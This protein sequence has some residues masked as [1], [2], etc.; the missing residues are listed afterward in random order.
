MK[1]F[2]DSA[3]R[4]EASSSFNGGWRLDLEER[5][6]YEL[7]GRERRI[8]GCGFMKEVA[9]AMGTAGQGSRHSG[10]G[11]E[12][13]RLGHVGRIWCCGSSTVVAI[14]KKQWWQCLGGWYN[15]RG[16]PDH[17]WIE[18]GLFGE[19]HELDS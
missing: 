15:Q 18:F 10:G 11:V 4:G 13:S 12:T 17:G 1:V 7:W 5:W 3:G 19:I 14:G 6:S 2:D 16:L 8:S 9:V